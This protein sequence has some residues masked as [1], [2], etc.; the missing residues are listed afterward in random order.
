MSKRQV[1][2]CLLAVAVVLLIACARTADAG[3]GT[4]SPVGVAAAMSVA[5]PAQGASFTGIIVRGTG[6]ATGQPD[7]AI[8]NLGVDSEAAEA[9]PAKTTT[10]SA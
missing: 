3:G 7:L 9:G 10:C 8:I 5:S 6:T 1:F 2:V 4:H